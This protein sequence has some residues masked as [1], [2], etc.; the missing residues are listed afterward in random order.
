MAQA[1]IGDNVKVHYTGKLKDGT[2]FDSSLQ[3]EPIQ[4]TIGE[5]KLIP[6]FEE[7]VIDMAPGEQSTIIIPS[8]KAYGQI[9]KEL[10]LQVERTKIPQ[11]LKPEI[12]QILKFQKQPAC[13]D[14]KCNQSHPEETIAFSII[15]ITDTH[16]TLDANHP[17]AGKD[18]T[19]DIE[20]MEITK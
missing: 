11:D 1:K 20:L 3:R 17:L 10:I 16:L 6:G 7:A 13:A 8:E 12:G 19:F 18:L 4:F 9:R 2:V 15:G 5:K 14:G